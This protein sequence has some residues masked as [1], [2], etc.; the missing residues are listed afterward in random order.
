M[1]NNYIIDV[2][3]LT[4]LISDYHKLEQFLKT[5]IHSHNGVPAAHVPSGD[6]RVIKHSTYHIKLNAHGWKKINANERHY[7]L[8]Y[9]SHGGHP[10][11]FTS[12]PHIAYSFSGVPSGVQVHA[13]SDHHAHSYRSHVP[14]IVKTSSH[15]KW[16]AAWDHQITLHVSV[17]G[18]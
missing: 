5:P 16:K 13:H 1:G 17:S 6:V 3:E 15:T 9:T 2:S 18:T 14:I 10:A 4:A 11:H 12:K 7:D 8:H